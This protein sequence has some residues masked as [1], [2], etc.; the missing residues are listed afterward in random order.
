MHRFEAFSVLVF[1]VCPLKSILYPIMLFLI[2]TLDCCVPNL[3]VEPK[4]VDNAAC[5]A[6]DL[7]GLCCPTVDGGF[8]DCCTTVPDECHP[9]GAC[10]PFPLDAFCEFNDYCNEL[11]LEGLCWYAVVLLCA[12]PFDCD[13]LTRSCSLYACI[14]VA[15]F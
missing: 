9:E 5:A 13:P 3:S 12:A 6:L 8:L 4:C 14:F 11:G 2:R 15:F 1:P 7:T 10:P